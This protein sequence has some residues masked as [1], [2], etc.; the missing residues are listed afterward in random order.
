VTLLVLI[1]STRVKAHI[2]AIVALVLANLVAILI[3]AMP[4]KMSV[5]GSILDVM[6][7]LFPIGQVRADRE[8]SI[9]RFA[10]WHSIMLARL[11][12]VLVMLRANVHPFSTCKALLLR[13]RG[14]FCGIMFVPRSV[15]L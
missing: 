7:G 5:R 6:V 10:F 9:L 1:A 2:A 4:A 12:G 11:V 15:P 13:A 3:F 14:F 8:G